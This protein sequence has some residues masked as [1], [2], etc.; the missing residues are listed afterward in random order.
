MQ[1]TQVAVLNS[2][3]LSVHD[4]L[5]A[6]SSHIAVL[7][8]SGQIV[9]V[10]EAWRRFSGQNG[11]PIVPDPYVG[12][13]Y[14]AVCRG[15]AARGDHAAATV[16]DGIEAVLRGERE[17][18]GLEYPCDTS[19]KQMWFRMSA[20]KF[21]SGSELHVVVA[22][23]DVTEE[24]LSRHALAHSEKILRSVLESLPVGVWIT[25]ADGRIVH[26]NAAGIRIWGG[27]RFVGP[28]QFGEYKGWWLN[29]GKRIAASEWAAARAVQKGET[30]IDEE[31]EIE[32]FDG[33]RKIIQNS[34]VPFFDDEQRIAGA[35][36]V[37]QD[38]TARKRAE[39]ERESMLHEQERLRHVALDANRTKDDF[40]ATL[41]HELRTPLQSI[42]GWSNVLRRTLDDPGIVARAA[43]AIER[44]AR[45]QAQ[46]LEDA[47]DINRIVR[48]TLALDPVDVDLASLVEDVVESMRPAA[49]EKSLTLAIHVRAD[50]LHVRGDAVRLQQV[51]WNLL[52]NA[53][54]FTP[55]G[56]RVEV[57]THAEEEWAVVRVVDTGIGIAAEFM[58]HLFDRFRQA[59]GG[60]RRRLGLGLGLAI[61]KELVER[62][63]GTIAAESPG[64]GLGATF[65]ARLPR[66]GS[67]RGQTPV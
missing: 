58:P 9:L 64:E 1:T 30:V 51:V 67:D 6:L 19:T 31:V 57:R 41:A 13:N 52:A 8:A 16:A 4:V 18:F 35:I 34:A 62:H 3:V 14:L 50:G 47:L 42:M 12:A 17:D 11:G 32:C 22:H 20:T 44:N 59:G 48:G 39:G 23:T 27:A 26:G 49:L 10:N 15:A 56:G 60:R 2:G 36:I 21:G 5:N 45:I 38:I 63:G 61:V 55:E 25:D 53:I 7:D 33:T 43:T 40:I 29:T 24:K 65:T 46:L 37:N 66:M 28:A 54:K